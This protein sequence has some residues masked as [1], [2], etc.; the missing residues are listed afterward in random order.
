MMRIRRFVFAA[1]W[2]LV[3]AFSMSAAGVAQITPFNL[4]GNAGIGLLPGNEVGTGANAGN[5]TASGGET[6]GGF[7]FDAS[8]NTLDF[9]FS[10]QGMTSGLRDAAGGIHLHLP[11]TPGDPFNESGGV[12][13]VLNNGSD[14]AVS[15]TTPLINIGATQGALAGSV[16]FAD[17]L[18]K[19]DDLLA[20]EIYLNIH[21]EAFPGGELRGTLVPIPEPTS[22]ALV[23]TAGVLGLARRR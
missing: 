19:V 1:V 2:G 17:K 18:D 8:T 16:S 15:L 14:A 9:S 22:V 7:V 5:S 20:G 11:G 13:F 6:G 21:S 23:L 10:F 4:A 12:E 3:A